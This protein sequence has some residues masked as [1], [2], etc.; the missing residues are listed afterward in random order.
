MTTFYSSYGSGR[1]VGGMFTRC[2]GQAVD[3]RE[4]VAIEIRIHNGGE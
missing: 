2:E 4:E 1:N 3:E